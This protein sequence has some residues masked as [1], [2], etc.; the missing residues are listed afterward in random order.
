MSLTSLLLPTT[1]NF[2]LPVAANKAIVDSC[3]SRRF[4]LKPGITGQRHE[5]CCRTQKRTPRPPL[6]LFSMLTHPYQWSLLVAAFE[7]MRCICRHRLLHSPSVWHVGGAGG[8]GWERLRLLA[9]CARAARN[10]PPQSSPLS[11]PLHSGRLL[12]GCSATV[13]AACLLH[14][15]L[16]EDLQNTMSAK[17]H[18]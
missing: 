13:G 18:M 6:S 3:D 1:S 15:Q 14:C 2:W 9:T 5:S 11:F 12:H 17:P 8:A 4:A 10:A 7:L 16:V